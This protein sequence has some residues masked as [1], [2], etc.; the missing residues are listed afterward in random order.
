MHEVITKVGYQSAE[1]IGGRADY[2]KQAENHHGELHV[3]LAQ[4]AD[5]LVQTGHDGNGGDHGYDGDQDDLGGDRHLNAHE[6]IEARIHL[7]G[8]QAERG[9][10]AEHSAEYGKQIGDMTNGTVNPIT[11]DRV[12]TGAN[13]Q[14]QTFAVG[15]IRQCQARQGEKRPTM[16]PPMEDGDTHGDLRSFYRFFLARPNQRGALEMVNRLRN[17]PEQY[18]DTNTGSEQH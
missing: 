11:K 8:P 3:D 10:N 5:A 17:A 1:H 18:A 2:N 7:L 12:Q 15:K 6:V 16:Q 9:R 14:G 13:R 4:Q